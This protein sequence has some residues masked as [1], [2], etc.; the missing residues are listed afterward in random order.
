MQS[1][2]SP[3]YDLH[4]PYIRSG[5]NRLSSAIGDIAEC[6]HS[7]QYLSHLSVNSV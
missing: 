2:Q 7:L 5:A 6:E 3:E 1:T 4:S